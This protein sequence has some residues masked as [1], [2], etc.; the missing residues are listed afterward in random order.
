MTYRPD[1]VRSNEQQPPSLSR[2]NCVDILGNRRH[3]DAIC[4]VA[5]GRRRFLAVGQRRIARAVDC[6]ARCADANTPRA[7]ADTRRTDANTPRGVA[8][9]GRAWCDIVDFLRGTI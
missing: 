7:I 9:T 5:N 4:R 1:S 8:D 2:R 3:M 6:N